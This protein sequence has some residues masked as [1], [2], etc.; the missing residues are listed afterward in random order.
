MLFWQVDTVNLTMHN[1]DSGSGIILISQPHP[2]GILVKSISSNS[3]AQQLVWPQDLII[4]INDAVSEPF[5][6]ISLLSSTSQIIFKH[7]R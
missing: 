5:P 2:D 3:P 4:R 1:S 7:S 6:Y